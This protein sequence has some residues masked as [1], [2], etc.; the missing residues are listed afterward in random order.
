MPNHISKSEVY[1][2]LGLGII[3]RDVISVLTPQLLQL[4]RHE[5]FIT[6]PAFDVCLS[7]SPATDLRWKASGGLG[8]EGSEFILQLATIEGGGR[9]GE[10]MD[11][12]IIC[13]GTPSTDSCS[14]L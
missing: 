6:K 9:G 13:K 3:H 14:A 2:C 12:R 5:S 1:V 10:Q 4:L 7:T 8:G 11:K